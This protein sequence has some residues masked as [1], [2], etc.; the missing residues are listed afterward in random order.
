MSKE[1]ESGFKKSSSQF[2][3]DYFLIDQAILKYKMLYE[4]LKPVSKD[5]KDIFLHWVMFIKANI[6]TWYRILVKKV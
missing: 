6:G 5:K 3:L 1:F 2:F 4:K